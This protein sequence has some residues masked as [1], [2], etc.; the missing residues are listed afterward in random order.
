[1]TSHNDPFGELYGTL[2]RLGESLQS[3]ME[4]YNVYGA[5]Q[6]DTNRLSGTLGVPPP[7]NQ[8]PT[9]SIVV[10]HIFRVLTGSDSGRHNVHFIVVIRT[11][12]LRT[13]L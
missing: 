4:L 9:A 13:V 12:R 1:M 2:L 3:L 11:I 6:C 5:Q 10:H 8:P 7:L